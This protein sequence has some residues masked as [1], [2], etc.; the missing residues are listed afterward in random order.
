MK[1]HHY[2]KYTTTLTVVVLFIM[3]FMSPAI[4]KNSHIDRIVSFGS[5]LS[6]TGNS[7]IWLSR[8]ENKICGTAVNVPPYSAIKDLVP[9]GPYAIG[10]HTFT[11]GATWL[12]GFARYLA[13]AGNVRPAFSHDGKK[14]S[15][16]A[17]G[18]ARARTNFPCRVN[19]KE[20][21]DTYF[22]DFMSTSPHTLITLE[23]GGNDVRDALVAAS[24]GQDPTPILAE[25]IKTIGDSL[26]QLYM[27][28]ARKFLVLNI[29]DIG[30]TPSVR[31]IPGA[32]GPASQLTDAFNAGL[33]PVL[34]AIDSLPG[35]KVKLLDIKGKLDEIVKHAENYGFTNKLDAC[36][37]PNQ[38]QPPYNCKTPGTYV[39]WDGIHPTQ[40]MHEIVAQQ[41]IV[42]VSPH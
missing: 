8:P 38:P 5:S 15:N 39:F 37:K 20:Q 29:P 4:A 24:T 18:G 10:G 31:M 26:Y 17:V 35:S 6:D 42:A 3:V 14:A 41:A 36:I 28:G 27:R 23:I 25:A 9:D 19:L 11:N 2:L 16:Y 30:K 33:A 34:Q 40:E 1:L 7:Y 32:S 12:E 21:L 22:A 13:L